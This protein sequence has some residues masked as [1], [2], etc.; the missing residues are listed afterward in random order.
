[1]DDTIEFAFIFKEEVSTDTL[2]TLFEF[3]SDHSTLNPTEGFDIAYCGE[4]KSIKT[5]SGDYSTAA[6]ICS[7]QY[8]ASVKV[9][10]S[11]FRFTIGP[12]HT[13]EPLSGVPHQVL[14]QD[15]HPLSTMVNEEVDDRVR[16]SRQ[17]F[18]ELLRDSAEILAPAWGFGK[19][20][21]ITP[22]GDDSVA[23]LADSVTPPLYDYNVF[24]EETVDHIGRDRLLNAPAWHVEELDTGAVYL[25]VGEPPMRH[26]T[27]QEDRQAVADHLGLSVAETTEYYPD[28]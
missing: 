4:D 14:R 11:G 21:G 17:D 25:V 7:T 8:G 16:Q 19:L 22:S 6:Q 27:G 2:S 20:G 28:E 10:Y 23:D 9:P 3:L 5:Q 26:S 13:Y 24:R 18:T 15:V 12:D 1:M